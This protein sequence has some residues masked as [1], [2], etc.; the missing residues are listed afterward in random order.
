[1]SRSVCVLRPNCTRPPSGINTTQLRR[2][3]QRKTRYKSLGYH[4][5]RPFT[6]VSRRKK[7]FQGGGTTHCDMRAVLGNLKS[8]AAKPSLIHVREKHALA[9]DRRCCT[10]GLRPLRRTVLMAG[11]VPEGFRGNNSAESKPQRLMAK[12]ANC[13]TAGPPFATIDLSCPRKVVV[14]PGEPKTIEVIVQ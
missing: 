5:I 2:S 3:F 7:H 1:M 11:P 13:L 6:L 9:N 10:P 12:N 4:I 8:P 14:Y